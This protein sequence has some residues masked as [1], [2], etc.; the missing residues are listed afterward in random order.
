MPY[1][2]YPVAEPVYREFFASV[3][4]GLVLELSHQGQL[5]RVLRMFVDVPRGVTSFARSGAQPFHP[6]E[7]VARL[8]QLTEGL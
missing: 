3:Q 2:I 5:Y 7:V 1:L 4:R 6:D 8:Q